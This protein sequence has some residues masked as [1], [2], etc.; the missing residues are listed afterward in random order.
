MLAVEL[1]PWGTV[2]EKRGQKG[3]LLGRCGAYQ[4]HFLLKNTWGMSCSLASRVAMQDAVRVAFKEHIRKAGTALVMDEEKVGTT[5]NYALGL[6]SC[7]PPD[8]MTAAVPGKRL[9]A[10]SQDNG[11]PGDINAAHT[12]ARTPRTWCRRCWR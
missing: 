8:V 12:A 7:I 3:A 11:F 5:A 9:A 4:L 2:A 10:R 6:L 1:H